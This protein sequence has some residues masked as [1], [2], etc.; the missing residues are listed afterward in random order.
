MSKDRLVKQTEYRLFVEDTK[1]SRTVAGCTTTRP[2]TR[3]DSKFEKSQ[4]LAEKKLK[5]AFSIYLVL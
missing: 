5:I 1:A 4:F 2:G 3:P